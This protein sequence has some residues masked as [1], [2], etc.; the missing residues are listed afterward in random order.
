[1]AAMNVHKETVA[2]LMTLRDEA[3]KM[4]ATKGLLVTNEGRALHALLTR[5]IETLIEGKPTTQPRSTHHA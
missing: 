5:F 2:S 3:A 1:M 4:A